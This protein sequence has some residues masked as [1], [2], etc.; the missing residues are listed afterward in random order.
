MINTQLDLSIRP[1]YQRTIFRRMASALKFQVNFAHG[2]GAAG[3]R[4]ARRAS[5]GDVLPF[6]SAMLIR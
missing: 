5:R 6:V 3:E 2:G 4:G 1:Q